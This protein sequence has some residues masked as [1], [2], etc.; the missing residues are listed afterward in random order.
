MWSVSA[1]FLNAIPFP[2]KL[3]TTI[4]C[5]PPGGTGQPLTLVSGTVQCD[6][7]A[8][9]RRTAPLII[10]GG[11]AIY[12]LVSTPGA[13]LQVN[14]GFVWSSSSKELVPVITGELSQAAQQLGDGTVQLTL[15][16]LWQKLDAEQFLTAYTPSTTA[17]RASEIAAAVTA[18]VPG[19]TVT[20]TASN[21]GTVGT[22]QTWSGSR[23]DMVAALATDGGAEAFFLPDGNFRVRDVPLVTATP[24]WDVAPRDGGVLTNLQRT[25]PLDRLYN[26]VVVTPAALDGSQTWTQ[27]VVQITDTTDP[28]HPS[29]I[30]TRP[31]FW[32]SPS[33]M[34]SA[35]AIAAGKALLNRTLGSTETLA[36]DAISNPAL[37]GGDVL[38]VTNITDDGDVPAPYITDG[39]TLDLVTGAMTLA[40]RAGGVP[41]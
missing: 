32:S 39:F 6:A 13:R 37:E 40:T 10:D 9:I 29:K 25:R 24:A 16:D 11:S 2:H 27:V 28:R 14:H 17:S 36:L 22:T 38:T 1:R 21:T 4:T 33:I 35:E 41:L 30:G 23:A 5:T 31:Y 12:D 7:T 18:A 3:A 8:K 34:S 26:T 20:N 15:A 19:T